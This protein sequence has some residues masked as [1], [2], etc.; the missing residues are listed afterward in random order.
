MN[1]VLLKLRDQLSSMID[2]I[3][4]YVPSQEDVISISKE[5]MKHLKWVKKNGHDVNLFEYKKT[6]KFTLTTNG[7]GYWD[8]QRLVYNQIM[9]GS[10]EKIVLVKLTAESDM[11]GIP[12]NYKLE[13]W[14]QTQLRDLYNNESK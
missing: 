2:V 7:G 8:Y 12:I 14:E 3:D 6:I 5:D 9:N 10:I 1:D 4:N 11:G 13:E